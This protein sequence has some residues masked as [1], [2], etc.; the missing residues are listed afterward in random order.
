M[1]FIRKPLKGAT[2]KGTLFKFNSDTADHKEKGSDFFY[3]RLSDS[4]TDFYLGNGHQSTAGVIMFET[5]S[6]LNFEVQDL[7]ATPSGDGRI[8]A[9]TDVGDNKV[10][11]LYGNKITKL[12]RITLN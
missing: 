9:I 8:T 6:A 7:V 10:R 3:K 4:A 12:K 11:S 5:T 2:I 1:S